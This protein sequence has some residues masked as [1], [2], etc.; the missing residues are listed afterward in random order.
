ME[1]HILGAGGWDV[2]KTSIVLA[3]QSGP[4]VSQFEYVCEVVFPEGI[5]MDDSEEE[6]RKDRLDRPCEKGH[7]KR[8]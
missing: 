7:V 2:A 4:N 5:L 8:K 6:P 3:P 1:V